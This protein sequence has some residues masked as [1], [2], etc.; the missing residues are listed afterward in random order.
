MLLTLG[1]MVAANLNKMVEKNG[2]LLECER[3]RYFEM[4][5][6]KWRDMFGK[7]SG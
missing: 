6:M 1:W 7:A 3:E 4:C 5:W 2:D